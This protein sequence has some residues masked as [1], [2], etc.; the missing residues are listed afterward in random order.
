[1]PYG[2]RFLFQLQNFCSSGSHVMHL[3]YTNQIIYCIRNGCRPVFSAVKLAYTLK[4]EQ[5]KAVVGFSWCLHLS[6][7]GM[8]NHCAMLVSNFTFS[9][10]F[11]L[12]PK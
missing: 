7:L 11:K 10:T 2:K 12:H 5:L 4:K 3:M 1:M 6:P 9:P 8:E